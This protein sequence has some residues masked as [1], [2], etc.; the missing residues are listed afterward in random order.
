MTGVA[1]TYQ[2]APRGLLTT[3]TS[4]RLARQLALIAGAI[5]LMAAGYLLA[6]HFGSSASPPLHLEVP[7]STAPGAA[8]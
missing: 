7:M 4:H 1:H 2:F 8:A 3:W 5:I 6:V